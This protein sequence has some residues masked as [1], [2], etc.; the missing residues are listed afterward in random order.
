MKPEKERLEIHDVYIRH[1]TELCR[2]VMNKVNVSN[3]EAQDIVQAAFVRVIEM[4]F[5]EIKNPRALLYKTSYNIAIDQKR[6]SGVRQRHI[7]AVVDTDAKVVEELSPA[8]IHDGNRQLRIVVEALWGMP[9]KRRKLLLM[10]RFDGLSYAEIAR[11]VDLS[12]TV[13]R[14]HVTK[15]LIDCQ[16]ALQAQVG[17][18]PK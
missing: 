5:S 13:V 14:K 11:R 10:N 6:H 18:N 12:E 9:K 4:D 15:A 8:R 7:Q 1:R 3:D 17:K 16:K 2:Y